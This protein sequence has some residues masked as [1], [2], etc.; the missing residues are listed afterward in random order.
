LAHEL[1]DNE[2][3]EVQRELRGTP[4]MKTGKSDAAIAER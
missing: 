3:R 4:I 1:I 2:L